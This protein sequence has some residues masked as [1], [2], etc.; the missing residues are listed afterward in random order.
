VSLALVY[1]RQSRHKD[2]DRTASPEV[3]EAAC[4]ALPSVAA[5][6]EVEV[7]ADLD[8]S[9]GK[10]AGRAALAR[11]LA[12]LEAGGVAVVA[13]YD[14]SRAFRNTRDALDFYAR[15]EKLAGVEVAFAH[16]R[17]DRSPA[18]EFTYTAMAAAHAMER[19]MTAEK[20]RAAY[21]YRNGRGEATGMPPYGYRRAGAGRLEV[22][23][24]PA[25]V[26]RRIFASYVNGDVSARALAGRLND[27]GVPRLRPRSRYGWLPDTVV[28]VLRNVAYTG[29]TYAVSRARREGE[30]IAASW[31]A[32]VDDVTFARA[33]ELLGERRVSRAHAG[34][35]YA[36]TGLLACSACGGLMRVNR[37]KGGV[38]YRCRRDVPSPCPAPSVSES[39][40][41]AWAGDLFD[42]L[43]ALRPAEFADAVGRAGA[44]RRAVADS[45]ESI[46]GALERLAKLFGWGHVTEEAYTAER[47]RLEALRAELEAQGAEAAP[48]M[49]L[50]GVAALWRAGS[51]EER[52]ALLGTM[53]ARI[54]VE[55]GDPRRFVARVEHRLEVE[56]L[57]RELGGDYERPALSVYGRG[58][59][60]VTLRT[61]TL[62]EPATG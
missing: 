49:R 46:A 8:V 25:E 18:G 29:R 35:P 59:G 40:L 60:G 56:E 26:V 22:D 55:D 41:L 62:F 27:E 17:F 38:Y 57:M 42:R 33:A 20:V 5:C 3:Q 13:A 23:E 1:V 50:D 52:R 24:E 34:R 61:R 15:M 53:F 12:R 44:R 10:T 30:L 39:R 9:G 37:G 51:A 58:E 47:A 36:F 43:E 2:G 54:Y 21:A 4:R 16:G 32:L 6:S 48:T 28:D 11:L 31:P 7:F 19:R 14:Q 45:V